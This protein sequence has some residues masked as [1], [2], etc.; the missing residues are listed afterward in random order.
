LPEILITLII[1]G[2]VAALT[3]PIVL[4]K[5]DRAQ[6]LATLKFAYSTLS[7]EMKLFMVDKNCGSKL[8]DC[9][10]S[11][12]FVFDFPKY[13]YNERG[14]VDAFSA[15]KITNPALA[16]A[17]YLY[18]NKDSWSCCATVS[19]MTDTSPEHPYRLLT[20]KGG[21]YYVRFSAFPYDMYYFNQKREKLRMVIEIYTNPKRVVPSFNSAGQVSPVY[22]RFPILGRE[23][24]TFFVTDSGKIIP[25]GSSECK[26]AFCY[27]CMDWK[28]NDGEGCTPGKEYRYSGI[29]CAARII[30]DDGWQIK[31]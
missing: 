2:G 25:G 3:V 20:P 8:S 26:G 7:S 12:Q 1:V 5:I 14:W 27:Y 13:L 31:Y 10:P 28:N 9:S 29:G 4:T 23:V 16:H 21:A 22:G 24:F 18:L 19:P 11:G 6:N 30:E 17:N 15:V